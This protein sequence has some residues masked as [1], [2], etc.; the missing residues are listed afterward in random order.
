M[1]LKEQSL[2]YV[3]LTELEERDTKLFLEWLSQPEVFERKNERGHFTSSA[4]V[5]N[6]E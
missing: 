2:N 4:W 6:P 1:E 3:P 5:L